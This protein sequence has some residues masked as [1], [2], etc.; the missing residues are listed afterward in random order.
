MPE[1]TV[2]SILLR[3]FSLIYYLLL[4]VLTH[5]HCH[6]ACLPTQKYSEASHYLYYHVRM[7]LRHA[8]PSAYLILGIG[9]TYPVIQF[10]RSSNTPST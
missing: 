4:H 10:H 5:R 8:L 2:L 6:Q 7:A 1:I 3:P 9:A